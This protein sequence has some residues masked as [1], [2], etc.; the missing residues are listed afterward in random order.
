MANTPGFIRNAAGSL[1]KQDFLTALKNA[2]NDLYEKGSTSNIHQLYSV[3]AEQ[4]KDVDLEI[5][6]ALY[7]QFIQ[8][9]KTNERVIR[10]TGPVDVLKEPS[11]FALNY[12]GFVPQNTSVFQEVFLTSND[13]S[14]QLETIPRNNTRESFRLTRAGEDVSS[15]ILGYDENQKKLLIDQ[16]PQEGSYVLG[17]I[18]KG[19]TLS[20]KEIISLHVND[21]GLLEGKFVVDKILFDSERVVI[22]NSAIGVLTRD[23]DYLMNYEEGIITATSTGRITSFEADSLDISYRYSFDLE[24]RVRTSFHRQIFAEVPRVLGPT[25]LELPHKNV[26]EIFRVFNTNTR[27]LLQ[28]ESVSRGIVELAE[29][30]RLKIIRRRNAQVR[31]LE[32]IFRLDRIQKSLSLPIPI[33]DSP[34]SIQTVNKVRIK[35]NHIRLHEGKR[36]NLPNVFEVKCLYEAKQITLFTG[37]KTLRKCTVQLIPNVDYFFRKDDPT[38]FVVTLFQSGVLKI[39]QKNLYAQIE[40]SLTPTEQTLE[41]ENRR[42]LFEAVVTPPI[43]IYQVTGETLFLEEALTYVRKGNNG[44]VK[45]DEE[46]FVS[47][48]DGFLYVENQDYVFDGVNKTITF[49]FNSRIE[50]GQSIRVLFAGVNNYFADYTACPDLLA[51]DYDITDNGIDWRPSLERSKVTIQ[52]KLSPSKNFVQL[53]YHPVNIDDLNQIEIRSILNPKSVL[54]AHSYNIQDRIL[55]IDAPFEEDT[56]SVTYIGYKHKIPVGTPYYVSYYYGSR[57]RNLRGTWA[58]LLGLNETSRRRFEDVILFGGQ[59]SV[60]LAFPILSVDEIV[61]FLK[62]QTENEPA[63]IVS[64]FDPVTN[65]IFFSPVRQY[66]EYVVAYNTEN[67]LTE[68][69]RKFVRGMMKAFLIGPTTNGIREMIT[70]FTNRFPL[71][72]PASTLAFRLN[73]EQFNNDPDLKSDSLSSVDFKGENIDFVPARFN[74]GLISKPTE[75]TIVKAP[76]LTN[77]R[78]SEGT[79]EFLIGPRFNGDD[80]TTNYFLDLGRPGEY[81]KDRLSIYKNKRGFLVFEVHDSLGKVWRITT[82]VGRKRKTIYRFLEAGTTSTTLPTRPVFST[83]DLKNNLQDDIYGAHKTEISIRRVFEDE[84]ILKQCRE[85]DEGYGY[86]EPRIPQQEICL[87]TPLQIAVHFIIA[88]RVEYQTVQGFDE[89]TKKLQAL[90]LKVEL[91]GGNLVIHTSKSYLIGNSA[92]SPVL[93]DLEERGHEIGLYIDMPNFVLAQERLKYLQETLELATFGQ[94]L[95]IKTFSGNVEIN[96]WLELGKQ[97]NLEIAAGF[98][99]PNFGEHFENPSPNVRRIRTS[100]TL[101][102]LDVEA[103][104]IV[105]LPGITYVNYDSPFSLISLQQIESSLLRSMSMKDVNSVNSWYFTVR[106]ETF[107]DDYLNEAQAIGDWIRSTIEPLVLQEKVEWVSFYETGNDFL[108]KENFI[109]NLDASDQNIINSQVF[110]RS[111]QYDWDTRLLSFEAIPTSGLYEI[112][113]VSGWA[114]YEESEIFVAIVYKFKTDDG[115]KPYYKLYLNG[116]L[117]DFITFAD[118]PTIE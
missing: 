2:L 43:R 47:S 24:E 15:L 10:G 89:I 65:R 38:T 85:Q 46:I 44:D 92:F 69:L 79:I 37:G 116:E 30:S 59:T 105:Y 83:T 80:E 17:F 48:M 32:N 34:T 70:T 11:A 104:Q 81:Y 95:N 7:D 39:G 56:F 27:Q 87:T 31:F 96:N 111:F 90:A 40:A 53:I 1:S 49:L 102:A 62:G 115:S 54:K 58:P 98:I 77:V 99:D 20:R 107:T 8:V 94:G 52:I 113:Y 25:S 61:V 67:A 76:A 50:P 109:N 21:Q 18:D 106:P 75:Q 55:V 4:M 64:N 14:I 68:D 97:L 86:N 78:M 60:Q 45:I 9:P 103:G 114:A 57:D 66:G 36:A 72:R 101:G 117:Q 13:F 84:T 63:T 41:S 28:V 6:K 112:D 51:I 82:D 29:N 88:D 26:S 118:L 5:K 71:V 23:I 12:I 110:V 73:D 33:E 35:T 108:Q 42:F 3:L 22:F 100:Y 19:S 91:S 16:V 93:K 74:S